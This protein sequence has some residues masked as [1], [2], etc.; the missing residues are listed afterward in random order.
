MTARSTQRLLG[1]S[2]PSAR[3]ALEELAD[4]GVLTRKSVERNTTCYLASEVVDLAAGVAEAGALGSGVRP[5][6]WARCATVLHAAPAVRASAGGPSISARRS[7][8][9]IDTIRS[10][11]IP[12]MFA[13]K[14]EWWSLFGVVVEG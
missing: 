6:P 13:P 2:F 10:G 5:M 1:V 12:R 9:R 14:A 11:L 7:S 3:S 8:S 4:A